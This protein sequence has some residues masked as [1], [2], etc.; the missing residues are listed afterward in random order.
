[1][2]EVMSAG[3]GNHKCCQ[4]HDIGRC[5]PLSLYDTQRCMKFCNP[6]CYGG[7]CTVR[8]GPQRC[9]CYCGFKKTFG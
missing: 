8:T 9:G 7:E 4:V 2:S 3:V 1:F 5:N 6:P